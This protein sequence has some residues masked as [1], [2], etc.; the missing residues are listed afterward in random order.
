[1]KPMGLDANAKPSRRTAPVSS[2]VPPA[3]A[4]ET[5]FWTTSAAVNTLVLAA[6]AQSDRRV[7]LLRHGCRDDGRA[8][9]GEDAL[10]DLPAVR[11][12]GRRVAAASADTLSPTQRDADEHDPPCDAGKRFRQ[13]PDRLDD[14]GDCS[15]AEARGGRSTLPMVMARICPEAASRSRAPCVVSERDF[16]LG[17][18]GACGFF[19]VGQRENLTQFVGVVDEWGQ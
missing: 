13:G 10:G 14:G 18:L 8:Q 7:G 5:P 16:E 19:G 6:L 2:A 12:D 4:A 3:R 11:E 15:A 9:C 17:E 1:M